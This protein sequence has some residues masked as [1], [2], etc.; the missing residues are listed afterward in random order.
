MVAEYLKCG[1]D[2]KFDIAKN[3]VTINSS[4]TMNASL[5]AIIRY[6]MSYFVG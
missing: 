3:R 4:S 5:S 2:T 6:K 1:L